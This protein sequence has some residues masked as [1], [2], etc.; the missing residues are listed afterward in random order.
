M[1]KFVVAALA[2]CLACGG[3]LAQCPQFSY[4]DYPVVDGS[5]S[6][7]PLSRALMS[8]STGAT[9]D[10][11]L[12]AITHHKTTVSFYELIDGRADLLIVG[13][14]APE[15]FDYAAEQGVELEMQP[16]GV[17]ALVFLVS[18]LNGVDDLSHEQIVGIYTGQIDNW[19]Q[20]GGADLPIIAYQRNSTAGS[21]VMMQEVVMGEQPMVD[22]PME[23]RP[24]EM[25]GLVEEIASYRNTADAIGYSIYYYVTEMYIQ[26][27]I[28]LL[29]V[30]GVTPTNQSISAGEYPYLQYNYAV[31][32]ADEPEDSP[33]R[34]LF[35]YLLTPEGKAL[36]EQCGYV[37]TA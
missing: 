35:D 30:D 28:K 5:T 34:Q 19:S 27:G 12:W 23:Y 36:M 32:R 17:D 14:P 11:A 18:D 22:A 1:K 10:E 21:Q 15:V 20:V 33:A 16:I 8:A 2:L 24:A 13:K 4:E 26:E 31:V 7:L 3:A 37:P 25:A 9:E 29:S 6:M